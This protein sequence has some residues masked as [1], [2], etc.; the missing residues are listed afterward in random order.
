MR[1]RTV[2][3][4][5]AFL[6]S[7]A[8]VHGQ[9]RIVF[10]EEDGWLRLLLRENV[11]TVAGRS[12]YP[13]LELEAFTHEPDE[14]TELLLQFDSLPLTDAAGRFTV[15]SDRPELGYSIARTGQAALLVDGPEDTLRL[16]PGADSLF[17]PGLEWGSFT[18]EFWLYPVHLSDGDVILSWAATA[19][20]ADSFRAQRLRAFIETNRSVFEFQNFFV[21][22]D[23]SPLTVRLESA[24]PL[25]PRRWSHHAVRF[26]EQTGLLEYLRDG[27]TAD[28]TYV[29]RTGRQDGSVYYPRIAPSPGEGLVLANGMIGAL[30]ELRI[31]RRFVEELAQPEYPEMGGSVVTQ[32]VDLGSSGAQA[33]Q[34]TATFDAPG[35]SEV[36]LY[37]RVSDQQSTE[38][39]LSQDEW[40]PVESG[41]RMSGVSGRFIQVRADLYPDTRTNRTPVLSSLQVHYLPDPAPLPPTQVRAVPMDGAVRVEWAP[42]RDRDLAGYRLFYGTESGRYFGTGSDQ[43]D[44]PVDVGMVTSVILDDL[45]NGRLYFFAISAY[46]GQGNA[47]APELSQEAAARPARV[48]R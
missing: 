39:P 34:I 31:V 45:E 8:T 37:Y 7:S 20:A 4:M 21:P 5:L 9:E 19:G 35:L 38:L 14:E 32:F 15:L 40:Q 28:I 12:G 17:R 16:R 30:D 41:V 43:G 44:S 1:N 22:P 2:L 26:D 29:S 25:I 13:D 48:Y 3:A 33:Q 36:L 6:L 11:I 23:G 10:G 47:I 46:D 24:Q 27:E 18:V 42:V